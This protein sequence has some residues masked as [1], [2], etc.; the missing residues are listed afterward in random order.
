MYFSASNN[1]FIDSEQWPDCLLVP[2]ELHNQ[3]IE[4]VRQGRILSS[5]VDGMP[6]TLDPPPPPALTPT[7][8]L[9]SHIANL[10]SDYERA[11]A[12]VRKTYPTSEATTWPVQLT[13]AREYDIWRQGGR[14]GDPPATPFLT[15]LTASR[16]A[17]GV[18]AGLEDL[19]DR[20]LANN[21][22]FEPA[23]GE[24]T[25]RRHR[26]ELTMWAHFQ[27]NDLASA[28]AVTWDFSLALSGEP[29]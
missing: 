22:I 9:L 6:I 18:G 29:T 19:V 14:V 16:D 7:E 21:S 27:N 13:E 17:L 20:V 24:L 26:A 1:A 23:I 28:L 4:Q 2:D 5:D 12:Q 25:A 8:Q 10:N 15:T 3:I 11:F